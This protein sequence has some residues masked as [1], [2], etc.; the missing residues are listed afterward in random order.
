MTSLSGVETERLR[1]TSDGKLLIG[2]D[3]GSIH[4]NRLL[5][6]G[7]TDRSETYVSIVNSTSGQGGILFA[8]TT[9][10]DTGGYRGQIRY[11]HSDD[12][13]IFKTG[14]ARAGPYRL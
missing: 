3:T 2:S 8:D 5:Q 11:H 12:S 4:G 10:N 1:I 6:V 7:K 13:M 9:T 14:A